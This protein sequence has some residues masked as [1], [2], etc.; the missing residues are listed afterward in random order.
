MSDK[1]RTAQLA[2]LAA[3]ITNKPVYE[4]FQILG[5]AG[6][7]LTDINWENCNTDPG[8]TIVIPA[9]NARGNA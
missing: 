8:A 7:R 4:Q 6:L 2:T 9:R 1:E 5:K 3:T